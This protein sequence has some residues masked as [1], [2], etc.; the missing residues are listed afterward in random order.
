MVTI[1]EG[2]ALTG[3]VPLFAVVG[4]AFN[5]PVTVRIGK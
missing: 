4:K 5:N 1:P 3:E 2:L